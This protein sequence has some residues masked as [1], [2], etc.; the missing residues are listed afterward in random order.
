MFWMSCQQLIENKF[1]ELSTTH[2]K[3]SMSFDQF[4]STSFDLDSISYFFDELVMDHLDPST[5]VLK[6]EPEQCRRILGTRR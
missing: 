4:I 1:D 3:N 6:L 5:K 2:R